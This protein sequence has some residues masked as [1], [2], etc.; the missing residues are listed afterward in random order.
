[1]ILQ[2]DFLRKALPLAQFFTDGNNVT[3]ESVWACQGLESTVGAAIDSR[4]VVAGDVF[5]ALDGASTDGHLFIEQALDKGALAIVIKEGKQTYVN[6]A[7]LQKNLA[8]KLVIV[9]ADPCQALIDLTRAWRALFTCPVVGITGSIGKTTTKEMVRTLLASAQIPAFVSYKNYNTQLGVCLNLLRADLSV[10]AIVLEVGINHKGEMDGI[11]Q[12]LRPTIGLI[13]CIAHS[14]GE[15][16]GGLPEIAQE[17]RQLFS[18]FKAHEVGIVFGDQEFLSDINYAHPISKFGFK[19]KNQVQAR[20]VKV[21][22]QASGQLTTNFTLKWYGQKADVCLKGNHGGLVHNAL[23]A[24]TIAYFL[25]IP[26]EAIVEG[27]E[28]YQG[29]E[30]RFEARQL[31][32]GRG[33]LLSDCYNANPESMRA[34]LLAFEQMPSTGK[35]V[36]VIGDMLELGPRELYWHRQVGRVLYKTLS[37]SAVILVGPRAKVIAKTAPITMEIDTANDWQEACDTLDRML[38]GHQALVLVKASGGMK[39][40]KMVAQ[41]TEL[42]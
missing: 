29:F 3:T 26:F 30:N 40:D 23:A 27:L 14:H 19:T 7:A 13:T 18:Y 34:A 20:K 24:S 6:T 41:V 5:F 38:S 31:K 8:G 15:G 10:K 17:K 36:V 32:D 16:L 11:A 35:K 2:K 4:M 21:N 1:V 25:Q 37:V 33:L 39:L 22:Y 12:L 9:V 28:S 42:A